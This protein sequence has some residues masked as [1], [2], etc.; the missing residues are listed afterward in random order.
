MS[1]HRIRL[2]RGWTWEQ[3]AGSVRGRF[4]LPVDRLTLD[5]PFVLRRVCRMPSTGSWTGVSIELAR[6][7]GLSRL[8]VGGQPIELPR[9]FEGV[10]RIPMAATAGERVEL[11]LEI[12]P[13]RCVPADR[14][15]WGQV[16]L[17]IEGG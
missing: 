1:E 2:R 8:F 7:E 6:V 16:A 17:L 13:E 9:G 11:V 10:H 12:E 15:D 3:P 5:Q 14:V 4:D